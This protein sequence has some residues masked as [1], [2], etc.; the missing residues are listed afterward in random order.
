V[1]PFRGQFPASKE[2]DD[3]KKRHGSRNNAYGCLGSIRG[4]LT[5]YRRLPLYPATSDGPENNRVLPSLDRGLGKEAHLCEDG[6]HMWTAE[7]G[8]WWT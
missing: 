1:S 3:A 6:T 4:G 2:P 7:T 5:A 8:K